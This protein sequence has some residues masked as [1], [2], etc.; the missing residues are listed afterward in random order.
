M[1]GAWMAKG[2]YVAVPHHS[3][4]NFGTGDF[5]VAAM[6]QTSGMGTILS[7]NGDYQDF[8]NGGI[9]LFLTYDRKIWFTTYDYS[10]FYGIH[11]D[12]VTVFDGVCHYIAGVRQNGQLAIFVDGIQLPSS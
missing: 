6:V 5:T 4:Y 8:G 9:F 11:S 7:C 10:G 1:Y 12:P 3:R 2:S